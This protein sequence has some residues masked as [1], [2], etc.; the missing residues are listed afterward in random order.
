[1]PDL[2]ISQLASLPLPITGSEVIA[3]V[4]TPQ[5]ITNK[6]SIGNLAAYITAS[7]PAMI[8]ASIGSGNQNL[9]SVITNGGYAT[10]SAGNLFASI[11]IGLLQNRL[12]STDGTNESVI[13]QFAGNTSI[14]ADQTI[15]ISSPR[16]V[17][18]KVEA[19]GSLFGTASYS[20]SS[21]YALSASSA[22]F[23]SNAL[24]ASHVKVSGS[25]ITVNWVGDL[26]QLTASV[27][28]GAGPEVDTLQSVTTRGNV[29]TSS[30]QM[31][32]ILGVTGSVRIGSG[33]TGTGVQSLAVG[34]N[35]SLGN[36]QGVAAFGFQT[37]V[38]GDWGLAQGAF[39]LAHNTAHAEGDSTTAKGYASHAEGGASKTFG[40]Y[41]H[42]EGI[43]TTAIGE[44]SHAEGDRTATVGIFSHAEGRFT[45]AIGSGSHAEGEN[46]DTI[47][48][49]SHA[50]GFQTLAQG[51]Y[52]HAEGAASTAIGIFSHAEGILTTAIGSG[53]HTNGYQ[54]VAIENYQNV[55]G[56]DN[57]PV[58]GSG[59][60]IVGDGFT[61]AW[62]GQ[63][64]NLIYAANGQVQISG[65]VCI[66][67]TAGTPVN[68]AA[69]NR[70]IPFVHNGDSGFIPFYI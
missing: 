7:I 32:S 54:T 17:I 55:V 14:S 35:N 9:Q 44:A 67:N 12:T 28:G 4:R 24:T 26:L 21:S 16:V 20:V 19:T 63:K 31:S 68:T 46:T 60:F 8:S 11:E 48:N 53:S 52:S 58:S 40:F 65:S 2:R 39:T 59:A 66:Q 1:M 27:S 70:W 69:P 29:T 3:I 51:V 10:S 33:I 49:Y 47:G 61:P 43:Q 22:L 37:S 34:T 5:T 45:T 6:V 62:G 50:E 57:I 25:G 64:H 30:I 15:F 18:D 13:S 41:S 42:A 56:R 23:A 38:V 36:N